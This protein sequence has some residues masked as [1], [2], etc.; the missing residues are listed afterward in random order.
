MTV[1]LTCLIITHPSSYTSPSQAPWIAPVYTLSPVG[2]TIA[3]RVPLL[4]TLDH[5]LASC[6]DSRSVFPWNI[7]S[8]MVS[9]WE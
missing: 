8:E 1:S 4:G 7:Q 2:G 6:M 5:V 9:E 3:V